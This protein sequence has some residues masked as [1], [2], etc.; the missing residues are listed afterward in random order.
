MRQHDNRTAGVNAR[1]QSLLKIAGSEGL[2]ES[3]HYQNEGGEIW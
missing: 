3:N 2:L 1:I